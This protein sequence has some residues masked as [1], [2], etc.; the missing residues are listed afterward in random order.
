KKYHVRVVNLLSG[1]TNL[2]V[3][4]K[5][6][7][8]DIGLHSLP[9]HG[10]TY[11]FGFHLNFF[12]TTLFFCNLWYGKFKVVFDAFITKETFILKQCGDNVCIWEAQDDGIYLHNTVTNKSV[13]KYTW[14]PNKLTGNNNLDVH[15]KSADD[16]LG[17]HS[18]PN[19]GDTYE[20]GFHLNFFG[21]T[22]FFCNL[23]YGNFHVVFDAFITSEKFVL[24]QCGETIC[25]WEA[26][27]DGIYL[28]NTVTNKSVFKY[29][30]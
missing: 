20:F 13:L 6:A 28:H 14:G 5:S 17:V 24:E 8:D 19:H 16:D 18:L 10:D 11:E 26:Q 29:K 2:D 9:N 1:N 27:D 3:H 15:C 30:W 21:T 22:L 4:C 12:G 23:W 7:D 25:M